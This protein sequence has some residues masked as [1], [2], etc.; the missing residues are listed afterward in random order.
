M[1]GWAGRILRVDLSKKSCTHETLD[2]SIYHDFL[3]GRGIA[4]KILYDETNADTD[5]FGP[6]NRLIMAVGPVNG[7]PIGCGRMT[8]MTKSPINGFL[9]EGNLGGHFAP[10]MKYAGLDAIVFQ[11]ISDEPVYLLI[12][13]D[14]AE[15]KPANHLWGMTTRETEKALREELGEGYQFRYIGPGGENMA[16]TAVIMGNIT[17]AGGRNGAGAVMG[18]K[19]LKA[20]AIKASKSVKIADPDKYLEALDEIYYEL[21]PRNCIDIYRLPHTLYGDISVAGLINEFGG[22]PIY[23]DQ[24]SSTEGEGC[25]MSE[26]L[27]QLVKKPKSC[28]GCTQGSCANWAE[29]SE[30]PLK[31]VGTQAHAGSVQALGANFGINNINDQL[32]NANLCNDL[33]LDHFV[34]YAIS[35][36]F[37]AYE[38]GLITKEDTGGIELKWGDKNALQ[39]M[40]YMIA[41]RRNIG[42]ILGRGL[43]NA[44]KVIANGAGMDFAL[45]VK[46]VE[47]SGVSPRTYYN[48]ALH[49]AISDVGCDHTRIYPPYPPLLEAIPEDIKLPFDPVLATDKHIPDEKGAFV[50]WALNSRAIINSLETCAYNPRG[51]LFTDQRPF[52]KIVSAATGMGFDADRLYTIG[53]RICNL[54]HS[55]NVRNGASRKDDKLPKRWISEPF[56]YGGNHDKYVKPEELERMIDDF[57]EASG[58]DSQGIPTRETLER[59]NL[60]YVADDLNV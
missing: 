7:T 47:Y 13:D 51:R 60:G 11:G 55:Y 1:Y 50:R 12:E 20:V 33:G 37:E 49:Y 36:A 18:S 8:V 30:G 24:M 16:S 27:M 14:H 39:Q 17:R 48:M 23:N 4:I 53:E 42:Q 28:Y 15:I 31:G 3:G 29:P 59:L 44:A 40:L 43:G 54:E 22:M 45:Q 35:W 19:K 21:D 32:E 58:W 56:K 38:K 46:G 57:Y 6:D 52:A 5:P 26:S 41:Y 10:Q 2:E 9:S 34:G 25:T